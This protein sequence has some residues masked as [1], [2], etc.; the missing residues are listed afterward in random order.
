[1][2]K[3][4]TILLGGLGAA[5]GLYGLYKIF[6]PSDEE[7]SHSER[8]SILARPRFEDNGHYIDYSGRGITK[9]KRKHHKK[10]HKKRK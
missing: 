7:M 10:S 6:S 2:N 5:V 1:M 3:E 4:E 9:R 8:A